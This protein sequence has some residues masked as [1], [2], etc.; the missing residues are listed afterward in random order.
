MKYKDL[1]V[2]LS[3]QNGIFVKDFSLIEYLRAA[4][5]RPTLHINVLIESLPGRD[6]WFEDEELIVAKKFMSKGV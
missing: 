4:R 1:T 5:R 6:Y 3:A 2:R